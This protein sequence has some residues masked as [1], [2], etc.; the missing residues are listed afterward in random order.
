MNV[1]CGAAHSGRA[2]LL[3]LLFTALARAAELL[4]SEFNAQNLAN[5]AWAFATVKQSDEK[6]FTVLAR[7]AE[8]QVVDFN[9]QDF[10]NT[11]GFL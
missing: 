6:L 5:T 10:A 2:E 3:G 11:A 1:A 8:R 7:A 9:E 4:L